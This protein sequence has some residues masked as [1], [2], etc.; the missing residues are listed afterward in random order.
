MGF[1]ND[2]IICI[3]I[4]NEL[5]LDIFKTCFPNWQSYCRLI[6]NKG[7]H[8]FFKKKHNNQYTKNQLSNLYRGT[9]C[10]FI[11]GFTAD[12]LTNIKK[13]SSFSENN[14][15]LI[16]DQNNPNRKIIWGDIPIF[17]V[18][19]FPLVDR[20]N[21]RISFDTNIKE[22]RWDYVNEICKKNP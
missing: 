8:F 11:G 10:V 13:D 5:S 2:N 9:K 4:D 1:S 3:D 14:Y 20:Y 15:S 16:Y 18:E 21:K 17:P 7:I 19:L 6:T 22:N 12:F